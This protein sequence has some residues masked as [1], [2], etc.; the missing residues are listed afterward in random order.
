MFD[1]DEMDVFQRG[2]VD[3]SRVKFKERYEASIVY[4]SKT[5]DFC[6]K[7]ENVMAMLSS[8]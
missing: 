1:N 6:L 8:C 5:S 3:L 4:L 7:P 2:G